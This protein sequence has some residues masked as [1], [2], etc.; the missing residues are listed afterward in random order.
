[1]KAIEKYPN[2]TIVRPDRPGGS[3]YTLSCSKCG[4]KYG[5]VESNFFGYDTLIIPDEPCIRDR[6]YAPLIARLDDNLIAK[7]RFCGGRTD[8]ILVK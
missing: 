8:F 4:A 1:M 3:K 2:A 5:I 7:Y 6:F